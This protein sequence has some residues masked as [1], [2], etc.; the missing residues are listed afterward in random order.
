VQ[1]LVHDKTRWT[2]WRLGGGPG[3]RASD[4]AKTGAA[5]LAKEQFDLIPGL[6]RDT[7]QAAARLAGGAQ[8]PARQQGRGTQQRKP[9]QQEARR[10]REAV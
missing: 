3:E 1:R 2:D 8:L 9:H 5:L 4:T 6:D 7:V 10:H